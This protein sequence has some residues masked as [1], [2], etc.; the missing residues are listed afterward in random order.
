[1]KAAFKRGKMV[2]LRDVALRPV[3]P[4]E[5]RLCV[6]ACGICG[7]DLHGDAEGKEA[8]FGHEVSGTILEVGSAASGLAV[9]QKVAL[10]SSS[11]C[12]RCENCRNARQELCADIQ[13]F[14]FSDS[15]GFAE[16]MIAPAV[17]AIPCEDLAPQ[18]ATLSEPLA[19]AIDMVRLA[20]ISDR[21]NVLVMGAG[22]IGLM[23][24][25][26]IRKKGARRVFFSA[27]RAQK[28]RFELA[29][30]LGADEVIDPTETSLAKFDFG[31]PVD[32]IL[33]TAPPDALNDAFALAAKGA[34]ITFVGIG[35]DDGAFCRFNANEFHFK[36][37]QLRAS[38]A[39][40]AL[41]TPLALEYLRDGVVPGE[42]LISHRFSLERIQE[43]MDAA[44]DKAR[45]LKVV[46]TP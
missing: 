42:S 27:Y 2:V 16:E 29:Q 46:V 25:M 7:S 10:E 33:I 38:F 20:E 44:R 32:R 34:M 17:S 30:E 35:V 26:L 18:V 5:V 28:I 12:G 31:C 23:A 1:M 19:V 45:A 15:F 13:S 9:G 21:S 11:A 14:F 6:A 8:P 3:R 24:Q 41:Y 4:H 43:A 22:P 39:S 36:K 40:P 37:L